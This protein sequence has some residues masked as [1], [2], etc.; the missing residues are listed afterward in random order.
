MTRTFIINLMRLA[1]QKTHWRIDL[2]FVIN[3]ATT[4]LGITLVNKP[5]QKVRI[6]NDH[7]RY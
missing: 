7:R 2:L 4:F 1:C 6:H 3:I 5:R